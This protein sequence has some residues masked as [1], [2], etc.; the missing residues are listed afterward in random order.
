MDKGIVISLAGGILTGILYG[1]LF[2][3]R[4][5]VKDEKQIDGNDQEQTKPENNLISKIVIPEPNLHLHKDLKIVVGIR[6]DMRLKLPEMASCLSD[7][8]IKSVINSITKN[9]PYI[10]TWYH[11]G[12]AKVCTKVQNPQMMED[13]IKKA[14][15]NN[16]IHEILQYK[17]QVAAIAVGPAPVD[18]VNLVTGHLKLL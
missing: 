16:V 1:V 18:E 12:Q 3:K 4:N 14:E 6:T 17:G 5:E 7:V 13:L 10:G 9:S 2:K 8:V 11:L 15:E